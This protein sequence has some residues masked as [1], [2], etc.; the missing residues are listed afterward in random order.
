MPRGNFTPAT[1][2]DWPGKVETMDAIK[3]KELLES[4]YAELQ[5]GNFQLLIDSLAQ[6][7]RWTIM[8]TQEWC[9]TYDGK[10]VVLA[11]LLEPVFA[12]FAGPGSLTAHRFIAEGEYVAVEARGQCTTKAGKAYNNMYCSIYRIVEGKI[13]EIAEY[14]DTALVAAVL[15]PLIYEA[16]ATSA[17]A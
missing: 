15:A 8:G 16:Q 14:M 7:A 13:K 4:I 12:V 2:Q 3:N 1:N 5:K 11:Q 9:R 10:Q 17:K 6:D